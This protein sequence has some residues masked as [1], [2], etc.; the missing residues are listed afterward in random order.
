MRNGRTKSVNYTPRYTQME[1]Y[2]LLPR[3][4]RLAMQEGAQAWDSG[5]VLRYYRKL[6]KKIGE[7]PAEDEVI[8]WIWEAHH[9][10][11]GNRKAWG[12]E[13]PHVLAK[14]TLCVSYSLD[15]KMLKA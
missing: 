7:Y 8:A 1:A 12:K 5:S 3:G 13:C 14:A 11:V 6:K 2:D 9:R 4:I 15:G 10:E